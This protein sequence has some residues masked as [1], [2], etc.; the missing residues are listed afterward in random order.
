MEK[1]LKRRGR[2]ATGRSSRMVRIPN[3]ISKE[4]IEKA[5]Y[6]WLP[7]LEEFASSCTSSPRHEQLRKLMIELGLVEPE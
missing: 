7:V 6:D 1:S 5:Y 3:E 2:P 4:F